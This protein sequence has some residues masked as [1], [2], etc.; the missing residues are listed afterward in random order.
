MVLGLGPLEGPALD[1]RDFSGGASLLVRQS[2]LTPPS[3]TPH[4]TSTPIRLRFMSS[5][6]MNIHPEEEAPLLVAESAEED[7]PDLAAAIAASL[8]HASGPPP[9]SPVPG[10]YAAAAGGYAAAIA[11]GSRDARA[12]SPEAGEPGLAGAVG[13]RNETGEYNCFLNVIVQCLWRCADFRQQARGACFISSRCPLAACRAARRPSLRIRCSPNVHPAVQP[14]SG[15]LVSDAAAPLAV[16]L[17]AMMC[18]PAEC[19]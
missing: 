8:A 6:I 11:M 12:G 10:S 5:Q 2:P 17:F 4:P 16:G 9:Q 18:C 3:H 13:L 19:F 15:V 14:L 1:A 7:D